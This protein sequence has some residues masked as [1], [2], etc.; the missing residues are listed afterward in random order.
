MD[1]T[2][3][4]TPA[5]FAATVAA[6]TQ[7]TREPSPAPMDMQA[8]I[9]AAVKVATGNT[10]NNSYKNPPADDWSYCWLHGKL[11]NKKHTSATCQNKKEGH[12]DEATLENQMGGGISSG[13]TPAPAD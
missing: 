3:L 11:R 7:Q 5:A 13:M 4:V 9:N 12:K 8:M 10:I 2:I 6:A 1:H